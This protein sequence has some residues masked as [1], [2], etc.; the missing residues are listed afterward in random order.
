MF[1]NTYHKRSQ[2]LKGIE[3]LHS[4]YDSKHCKQHL[5]FSEL[6][7]FFFFCLYRA[8]LVWLEGTSNPVKKWIR[9]VPGRPRS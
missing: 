2:F 8:G 1:K 9:N 5:L 6:V 3:H 4:L 7:F